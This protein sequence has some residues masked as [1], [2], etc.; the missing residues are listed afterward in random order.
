[1]TTLYATY[2]VPGDGVTTQFEFSFSG[3]Y[4]DKSHVKAY[5]ED[6]VTLARTPIEVLPTMF[7]GDFTLNLGVA[8]PVG[9][10]MVIYRDTP[11]S[12]PL[13]DFTTGSRLTEANLDKVA[14]QSVFIGAEISDATNADVLAAATEASQSILDAQ[15]STLAAAA[16]AQASAV[17]ADTS[18][19]NALASANNA[20]TSAASILGA[21]ASSAANA[22][23]AA[24]SATI[25]TTK[26]AEASA[27]ASTADT[28]ATAAAGSANAAS[29]SATA[30][31]GSAS[32]A[33]AQATAAASSATASA[34][35]ATSASASAATATAQATNSSNSA[36]AAAVSA[37]SASASA[38]TA[39]TQAGVAT[40]Q[41]GIATT[42]AGNSSTSATSAST[43]AT[44][45]TTQA[46]IATTQAGIATTKAAE[47]ATSA[48]LADASA[49]AANLSAIAADASA[50]A[51]AASAAS[52]DPASLLT[53]AGNLSGLASPA[54][55]R[56]NLGVEIGVDVQAF[57][58]ALAAIAANNGTNAMK[59]R[60]I[61]G[62]MMID[63]R[64]AG[65]S[66]TPTSGQYTIDRWWHQLSQ[67]SKI[68]VQRSSTAPAGF[69]NSALITSLSAYSIGS[70][71]YF[72]I[73]QNV[74]GFNVADLG[75]GTAS[76]QTI[77][78]SFWVRSSLT[79]TFG[80]A[81]LNADQS[82]AYPFT[83]TISS[84][85]TFEYKTVTIAGDTSGTWLKDNSTGLRLSFGLGVG[86]SFSST[87][88]SWASGVYL[89]ATGATSV[90]GTSGATFY[91]TGVQLE[92]GS[93]ATSFDYRPYGTELALC[94]R[95]FEVLMKDGDSDTNRPLATA[96]DSSNANMI[97]SFKVTKRASASV[98]VSSGQ[99]FTGTWNTLSSISVIGAN[100]SVATINPVLTSSYTARSAYFIRNANILASAE[101]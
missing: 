75:W 57:N 58:A 1:M 38:T 83:Y 24:A 3:G 46:G 30:A 96:Y 12:G 44:T 34:S 97:M 92:K 2:R 62:A 95:Y 91:I 64:N 90:V 43:S 78:V 54:T 94:Q 36:S 61:N 65:A 27:S 39:T 13:V 45:A 71:D 16:A 67:T 73:L 85:N 100:D 21:V 6:A 60:I 19:A 70:S 77:T 79:G 51:A 32:T 41:A 69:V 66:V 26:A 56:D 7:V 11:K 17:S 42:Q 74:E 80:G 49:N 29:A 28:R 76:A 98:T 89:S 48:N 52:I 10:N 22:G 35:S 101:L 33:S 20:A 88:G 40:T 82:R 59:N 72:N 18:E 4:M 14:S 84:A 15:A 8:A 93:T 53:K 99:V 81:V 68:S 86:S 63:Q 23:A 87:A 9:K 47:A 55:A 37:S 50:D 31:A 5:I 25:A